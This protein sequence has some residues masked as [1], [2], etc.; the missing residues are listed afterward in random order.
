MPGLSLF[1]VGF[2]VIL[3]VLVAAIWLWASRGGRKAKQ[4]KKFA[5]SV[6]DI[7][8]AQNVKILPVEPGKTTGRKGV[9]F[10]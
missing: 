5:A 1:R 6:L 3:L 10:H 4:P 9:L 8:H 2:A 7:D